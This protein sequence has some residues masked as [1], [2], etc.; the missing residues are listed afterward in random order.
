MDGSLHQWRQ[1]SS[2]SWPSCLSTLKCSVTI[3]SSSGKPQLLETDPRHQQY[4]QAHS[5]YS[6]SRVVATYKV[7]LLKW[8]GDRDTLALSP[9]SPK[10]A[11]LE[12]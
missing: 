11:G 3:A 8:Q 4:S 5:L 6:C 7:P 2:C 1:M 10:A 12:R 9:C